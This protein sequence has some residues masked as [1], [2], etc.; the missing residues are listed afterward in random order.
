MAY[1]D[2]FIFYP[3]ATLVFFKNEFW[4]LETLLQ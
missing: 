2:L 4:P 1:F 3:K